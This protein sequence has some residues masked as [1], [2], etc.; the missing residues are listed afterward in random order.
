MTEQQPLSRVEDWPPVPKYTL[1]LTI[2]GNTHDELANELHY[3]AHGT[4]LLN[5]D[6]GK[7]DEY[8]VYGGRYTG[9]L[10]HTNPAMTPERYAADLDA[11]SKR[12]KSSR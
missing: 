5:S 4:H 2:T 7:R 11:W 8:T 1:T 10:E 12:R 6:Y 3:Q 9:R